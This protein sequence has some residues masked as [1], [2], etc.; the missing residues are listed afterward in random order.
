MNL[1]MKYGVGYDP[2]ASACMPPLSYE[3]TMVLSIVGSVLGILW[4]GYNLL[5]LR[6]IDLAEAHEE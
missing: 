6:R 1:E 3:S 2:Y 5:M 4:T